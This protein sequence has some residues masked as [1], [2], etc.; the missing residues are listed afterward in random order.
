[1]PIPFD[2][3]GLIPEPITHVYAGAKSALGQVFSG[4]K[5]LI[6]R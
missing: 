2:P 1:L 4:I 3:A 5:N 6:V